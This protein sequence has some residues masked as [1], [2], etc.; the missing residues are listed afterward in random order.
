MNKEQKQQKLK[1]IQEVF[2]Q[3]WLC[4][5]VNNKNFNLNF[6]IDKYKK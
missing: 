6:P 4:L 3:T 2:K 5:K 1:A